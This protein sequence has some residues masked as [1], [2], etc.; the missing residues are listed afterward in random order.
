[1]KKSLFRGVLM[2]LCCCTLLSGVLPDAQAAELEATIV[3]GK[4]TLN[5]Q[6]IDNATAKYPL[7]LYSNIT[8]FPMTDALCRFMGLNISWNNE[9]WTLRISAGGTR[10]AYVAECAPARSGTVT[11]TL[12]SYEIYINDVAIDNRIETYPIFNYNDVTY[13]PLTFSYAYEAFGWG[14]QWDAEN[15]LRIDTTSAP[16]PSSLAASTGIAALDEALTVLNESYLV[17]GSYQG[18]LESAQTRTEFAA[19]RRVE[20]MVSVSYVTFSAEPFPFFER[21]ISYTVNYYPTG[22][23][24]ADTEPFGSISGIGSFT[25]PLEVD[26]CSEAY[27]IGRC[28]AEFQ[29]MGKRCERIVDAEELSNADGVS[30]WSLTVSQPMGNFT[31][32]TAT[33]GVDS[34]KRIVTQIVIQTENQTLTM[35]PVAEA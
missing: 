13:F 29:F 26:E 31:G 8:Y 2:L 12:P 22:G 20:Q 34:V 6:V 16:A 4:V 15:G 7:L 35:L 10:S 18:V 5:G 23:G 17:N 19:E 14:Y 30:T 32:Y 21:G 9:A 28:F 33:V 24:F 3:T 11:V 1:M 27:Y 25:D